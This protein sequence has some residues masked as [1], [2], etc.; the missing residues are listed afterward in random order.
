[1]FIESN[2][3][4]VKTALALIGKINGELRL[5]LCEMSQMNNEKLQAVLRKMSLLD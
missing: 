3:I 1:M 2:P 4:P 5:P